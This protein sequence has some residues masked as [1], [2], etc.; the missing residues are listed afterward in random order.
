[1][2]IKWLDRVY[3]IRGQFETR[4]NHLRLDKNERTSSFQKSLLNSIRNKINTNHLSTYPETEKLYNTLAKFLGISKK[5]LVITAGS[6]IAIKNC[7]ELIYNTLLCSEHVI[8]YYFII[9]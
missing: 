9:N 1:M 7:F 2:Q 6:D 3:R 5:M 8:S 4:F